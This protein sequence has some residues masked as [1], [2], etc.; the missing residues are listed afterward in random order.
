MHAISLNRP[1]VTC[2]NMHIRPTAYRLSLYYRPVEWVPTE[3][4]E[5]TLAGSLEV[6]VWVVGV[7][8]T[9]CVMVSLHFSSNLVSDKLQ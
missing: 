3:L 6:A 4:Q 1:T 5:L 7:D 9:S 8:S 2:T